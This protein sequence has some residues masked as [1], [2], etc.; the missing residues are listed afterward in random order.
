MRVGDEI[1]K[2]FLLTSSKIHIYIQKSININVLK[3]LKKKIHKKMVLELQLRYN[4]SEFNF[5]K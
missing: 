3:D 4:N 1:D 2:V 5:L